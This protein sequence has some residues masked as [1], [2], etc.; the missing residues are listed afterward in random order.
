MMMIIISKVAV[1]LEFRIVAGT[2]QE[3][4]PLTTVL[5]F[6]WKV[7]WLVTINQSYVIV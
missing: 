1:L 4:G 7:L 6:N 5:I 3:G 2:R